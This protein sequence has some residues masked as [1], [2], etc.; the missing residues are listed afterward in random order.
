M[1]WEKPFEDTADRTVSRHSRPCVSITRQRMQFSHELAV[2][3]NTSF[4]APSISHLNMS[5]SVR[6]YFFMSSE[7]EVAVHVVCPT[8]AQTDTASGEARPD[9]RRLSCPGWLQ[10]AAGTSSARFPYGMVLRWS[11]RKFS[12]SGSIASTLDSGNLLKYQAAVS[13]KLAPA[14]RIVW[15]GN[16]GRYLL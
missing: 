4:S 5:I 11:N 10:R 6:P 2:P 16:L 1:K 8:A 15:T 12:G 7:T 13:P 14:S 3:E 9:D